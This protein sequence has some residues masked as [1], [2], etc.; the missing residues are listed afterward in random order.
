MR[1]FTVLL[2]GLVLA[3]CSNFSLSD[4]ATGAGAT[5]GATTSAMLGLPPVVTLTS[6]AGGAVAGAALVGEAETVA[7]VCS[8]VPTEDYSGCVTKLKIFELF[9]T[10]WMWAVG[11]V[12][13]LIVI[14]WLIPGPQT[15][16][17]WRKKDAGSNSTHYKSRSNWPDS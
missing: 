11:G 2:I 8:H 16:L 10:L 13:G 17:F 4:L 6:A 12:V 15:L 7:D 9:N 5:A 1:C 14:A 3:G